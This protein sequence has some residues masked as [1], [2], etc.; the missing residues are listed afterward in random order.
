M[1]KKICPVCGKPLAFSGDNTVIIGPLE[2]KCTGCKCII[3]IASMTH[4]KR[5]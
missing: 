4:I 5:D 1:K 2:I 3:D